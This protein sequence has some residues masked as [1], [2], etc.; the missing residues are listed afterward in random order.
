MET[1]YNNKLKCWQCQND[2]G[3]IAS[4]GETKE[5]AENKLHSWSQMMKSNE[6]L[7]KCAKILD[8]GERAKILDA[9]IKEREAEIK[10]RIEENMVDNLKEDCYF[11]EEFANYIDNI[12]NECCHKVNSFTMRDMRNIAKHFCKWQKAKAPKWKI[13]GKM[14]GAKLN[15]GWYFANE[16]T[17][18]D[19]FDGLCV[20]KSGD[21]I[22]PDRYCISFSEL[23]KLEYETF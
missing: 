16:D 9:E 3:T 5:I 23:K 18:V 22:C 4:W 12:D 2:E 11:E 17:I 8:L 1:F 13:A 15:G 7:D 19:G 21:L 6:I 14:N 10:K 20:K